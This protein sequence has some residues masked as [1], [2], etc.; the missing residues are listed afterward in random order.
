MTLPLGTWIAL[1]DAIGRPLRINMARD[2]AGTTVDAGHLA[3][4]EL[5]TTLARSSRLY[6]SRRAPYTG[7]WL[8]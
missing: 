5:V 2:V 7:R 1:A 8:R 3:M 6:D 4:Q